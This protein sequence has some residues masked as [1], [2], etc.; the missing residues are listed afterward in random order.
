MPDLDASV[1]TDL[2]NRLGRYLNGLGGYGAP[3]YLTCGGSAAVYA[4]DSEEGARVFKVFNP[5][6]LDGSSGAAERRRLA[7]QRRLIGH[8]CP[9]LVNTYRVE[10]AEGTAFVEMEYIR[11]PSLKGVLHVVPD[12]AVVPLFIQLV[13]AVKYLNE[14]NIVH[15]DIKPENI[16][17]SED[18]SSL[19][20]LDLGVAREMEWKDGE[21][22]ASTDQGNTRPFLA[23]AQYSSPEYLFRL[24]EPSEKLW[25]GLNFY[26]LGAVLHDLINK[27]PIFSTEVSAGN[28]WLVARAVLMRS[29]QFLDGSPSRLSHL[30]ALA[31][32][33]LVKD[34]D[35]RLQL[36]GWDDF[37]LEGAK[38]ARMEL[39]ARLSR[40]RIGGGGQ[41]GGANTSRLEFERS[42][43]FRRF[44]EAIRAELLPVCGTDMPIKLRM[45]APGERHCATIFLALNQ[46]YDIRCDVYFDWGEQIYESSSNISLSAV[47]MGKAKS[48][49]A[50]E[51]GATEKIVAVTSILENEQEA[52]CL[53]AD[54]IALSAGVALDRIDVGGGGEVSLCGNDLQK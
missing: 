37:I 30:K 9:S 11:W 52:V 16:H 8:S 46:E 35:A 13:S 50:P 1:I 40:G 22:A 42:E 27:Q 38:D 39:R 6:F 3:T 47:L 23:T 17:V 14:L 20:L 34:I 48:S 49:E 43:F 15:R 33:C 32:R 12:D 5:A 51:F 29:P 24:D 2:T 44:S 53:V 54:R 18:F 45:S 31:L 4:V 7:L 26:Q 19:K 41:I 28:R 21:E 10:E 36:V 25:T